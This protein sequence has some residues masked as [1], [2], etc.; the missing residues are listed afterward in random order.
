M[1]DFFLILWY[2]RDNSIMRNHC[3]KVLISVVYEE[4][5]LIDCTIKYK[6]RDYKCKMYTRRFYYGILNRKI[7]SKAT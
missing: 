2:D 5:G 7:D 1:L 4:G 3:A 6:L